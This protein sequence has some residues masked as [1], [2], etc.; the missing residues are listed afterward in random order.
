MGNS[1]LKVLC[2]VFVL[3]STTIAGNTQWMTADGYWKD[4]NNWSV[5]GQSGH[6][7]PTLSDEVIFWSRDVWTDPLGIDASNINVYIDKGTHAVGWRVYGLGGNGYGWTGT[8]H[9]LSGGSLTVSNILFTGYLDDSAILVDGGTVD[10]SGLGGELRVGQGNNGTF[11]MRGGTASLNTVYMPL[12]GGSGRIYMDNGTFT[13]KN[14]LTPPTD[15]IID[16]RGGLM[17]FAYISPGATTAYYQSLITNAK[18]VSFGG[19]AD[20]DAADTTDAD[21]R[22]TYITAKPKSTTPYLKT[23]PQSLTV[24]EQ[25]TTSASYTLVLN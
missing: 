13:V 8:L 23:T 10:V 5:N 18:I 25:G 11:T 1:I 21:G 19:L 14:W 15:G 12:S 24:N 2:L 22:W 6:A 16:I 17:R 9:I 20:V 4:S 3:V 7:V